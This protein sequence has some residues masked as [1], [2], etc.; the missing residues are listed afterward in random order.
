MPSLQR[1][2]RAYAHRN[3]VVVGIDQG[4]GDDVVRRYIRAV[5]VTYPILLD[6]DQQY[7]D[8]FMAVG[9]PTSVFVR[10]DGTVAAVIHG[11]M[12]YR[13][14]VE[15]SDSTLGKHAR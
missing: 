5:R 15:R 7:G 6:R 4:E 11:A 9:I 3:L 10:A 1:L 2:S 13:Q 8:A 14:M 12:S